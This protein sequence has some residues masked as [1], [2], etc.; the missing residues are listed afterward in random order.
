MVNGTQ[1]TAASKWL[2]PSVLFFAVASLIAIGATN[3]QVTVNRD[4]IRE[5][6]RHDDKVE[7]RV[8]ENAKAVA[9]TKKD[10]EYIRKQVDATNAK[11]DK[12]MDK[13]NGN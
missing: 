12:I 13:L 9:E 10:I 2:T 3:L 11:L 5:A 4:E 8:T 6:K 1:Q 7:D